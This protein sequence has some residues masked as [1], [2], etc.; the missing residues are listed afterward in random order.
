MSSSFINSQVPHSVW[1]DLGKKWRAD[2]IDVCDRPGSGLRG[3][4]GAGDGAALGV[5]AAVM[6][7][8]LE[9]KGSPRRTVL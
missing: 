8:N 2:V 9:E 7:L 6:G 5:A 1:L 4:G 3:V